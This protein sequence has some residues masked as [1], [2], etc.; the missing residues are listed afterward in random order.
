MKASI[1]S[2]AAILAPFVAAMPIVDVTV[3]VTD[4]TQHTISQKT[5]SSIGITVSNP[6]LS[7]TKML[8]F[9]RRNKFQDGYSSR[10]TLSELAS[11]ATPSGTSRVAS[12][13]SSRSK[14]SSLILFSSPWTNRT[15]L[16]VI[17]MVQLAKAESRLSG[18][19][20]VP[21]SWE[22]P[23]LVTLR[24]RVLPGLTTR[25]KRTF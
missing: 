18:R 15:T 9:T 24:L 6:N 13:Q 12:L 22:D 16:K 1:L 17:L 3:H 7:P 8:S 14:I 25:R 20:V 4:D 19:R 10:R 2:I 11:M 23:Q 5:T 21:L